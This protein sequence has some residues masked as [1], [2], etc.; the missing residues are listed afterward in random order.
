MI[1]ITSPGKKSKA[2]HGQDMGECRKSDHSKPTES[3]WILLAVG[4]SLSDKQTLFFSAGWQWNY[5]CSQ[6]FPL[7]TT[8]STKLVL[9]LHFSHCAPGL[10]TP[11]P[12]VQYSVTAQLWKSLF[13]S[14]STNRQWW[15]KVSLSGIVV[16]VGAVIPWGLKW[17]RD[18]PK[19]QELQQPGNSSLCARE[20]SGESF[21][22]SSCFEGERRKRPLLPFILSFHHLRC[23]LGN[24]L[25]YD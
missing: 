19:R 18:V 4:F 1:G 8:H 23:P 6:N 9:Q 24:I 20:Q 16:G 2:K 12:S 3:S 17:L 11:K 22:P 7:N 15:H 14:Q 25:V 5:F 10:G 13:F 21:S